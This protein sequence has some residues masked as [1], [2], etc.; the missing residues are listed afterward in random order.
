MPSKKIVSILIICVAIILSVWVFKFVS[1]K[2]KKTTELVKN[3]LE[4]TVTDTIQ[5]RGTKNIDSDSDGLKDWQETLIGT[6]IMKND[7]DGDGT[8]DGAEVSQGRDP[9]K[10]GPNDKDPNIGTIAVDI[11]TIVPEDSSVTSQMAKDFMAQYLLLKK[12]NGQVT[13][14]EASKIAQNTLTSP[15]YTKATGVLY[16]EKDIRTSKTTAESVGTYNSSLNQIFRKHSLSTKT[17]NEL[18]ILG[19][20]VEKENPKELEKL[21]PIINGYKGIVTDLVNMTVP[22]DAV[23]TH[24]ALLNT[25]SNILANIEAM[26]QTFTD[27]V[28]SFAAVSQYKQHVIDMM[29]AYEKINKYFA[30]KN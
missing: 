12:G 29:V 7:S 26:R 2:E 19:V 20:A 6:D 24:L 13:A 16:S 9:R 21:D 3:T 23:S 15:E 14:E 30:S 10:K 4:T 11:S 22:Q 17:Q 27:P 25:S 5:I 8:L 18:A 1:E 28:K